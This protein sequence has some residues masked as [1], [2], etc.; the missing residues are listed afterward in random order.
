MRNLR[1][2]AALIVL[3]PAAALRAENYALVVGVN[4]C[5]AFR[6][7]GGRKPAPLRAAESDADAVARLLTRDYGFADGN[8]VVLKGSAATRV[9]VKDA[10]ASLVARLRKDDVF[11]FHFS[12]HGTRLAA[13]PGRNEPDVPHEAL[14]P[15]DASEGEE[16]LIVDTELG[17]W[18]DDV[19]ARQLTVLL[20]CCHAGGATK[21]D[22]EDDVQPRYLPVN[23][24]L[25]RGMKPKPHPWPELRDVSKSVGQHRTAF[26]ACGAEQKAYER[27]FREPKPETRAGQF[28][29]YFLEGL[30]DGKADADGDGVVTNRE[31]HVYIARRLREEFNTRREPAD[32]QEPAFESDV[33]DAAVFGL[34]SARKPG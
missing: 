5:P 8:V 10:F 29:R 11:V 3:V 6:L 9:R 26:F 31:L 33:P 23:R 12:G 30:R 13:R 20:D 21:G 18:L 19:P 2:T 17:R 25:T 1:W 7:A 4:E 34:K 14:C 15:C 28:T 27:K 24:F 32:R 16:N 22:D